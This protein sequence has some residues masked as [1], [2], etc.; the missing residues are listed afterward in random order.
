MEMTIN[1]IVK[2]IAESEGPRVPKY[3]PNS[4]PCSL[5]DHRINDSQE[6]E[7]EECFELHD[8][9]GYVYDVEYTN[10]HFNGSH[11]QSESYGREFDTDFICPTCGHHNKVEGKQLDEN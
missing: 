11:Y 1:D 9:E 5:P 8:V 4:V 7:C 10:D 6:I 3:N 2:S